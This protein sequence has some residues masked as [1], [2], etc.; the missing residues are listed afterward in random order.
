MNRYVKPAFVLFLLAI[1]MTKVA[2]SIYTV[3][4]VDRPSSGSSDDAPNSTNNKETT[5]NAHRGASAFR[6]Q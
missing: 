2:D 5:S 3:G 4:A 6:K 1:G